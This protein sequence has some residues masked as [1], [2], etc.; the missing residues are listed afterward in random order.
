MGSGEHN[1]LEAKCKARGIR[2]VGVRFDQFGDLW[3]IV[4]RNAPGL[5]RTAVDWWPLVSSSQFM[6][7]RVDSFGF[8]RNHRRLMDQRQF[9]VHSRLIVSSSSD[10][11]RF[12][13]GPFTNHRLI[14]RSVKIDPK[15]HNQTIGDALGFCRFGFQILKRW[16]W[17]FWKFWKVSNWN[18]RTHS[19]RMF[20]SFEFKPVW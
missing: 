2:T 17:N 3:A 8:I 15:S 19:T 4:I 1:S 11:H 18:C 7:I 13:V 14:V 12:I 20:E 5:Q 10:H 6:W 9:G 16:N